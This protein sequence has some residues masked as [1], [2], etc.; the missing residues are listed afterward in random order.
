M[1]TSDKTLRAI[2]V[3]VDGLRLPISDFAY[4]K[5]LF[6]QFHLFQWYPGS[7]PLG[8]GVEISHAPGVGAAAGV[9]P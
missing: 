9:T 6:I 1:Q 5:P 8:A 3:W 7:S 2:C 4:T